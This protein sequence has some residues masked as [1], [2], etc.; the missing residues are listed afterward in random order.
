MIGEP[1]GSVESARV[2]IDEQMHASGE[3]GSRGEPVRAP[4]GRTDP[5]MKRGPVRSGRGP[6]ERERDEPGND[7]GSIE[8]SFIATTSK[9]VVGYRA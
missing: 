7:A 9:P 3:R 8:S 4:I 2:Q 1:Q 5:D 6:E